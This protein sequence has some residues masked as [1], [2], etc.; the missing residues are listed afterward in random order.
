MNERTSPLRELDSEHVPE[1]GQGDDKRDELDEL[2][3]SVVMTED[4]SEAY[5]LRMWTEN[6]SEEE[7]TTTNSVN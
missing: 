7:C 3:K 5:P 6:I 1:D 2:L 4:S